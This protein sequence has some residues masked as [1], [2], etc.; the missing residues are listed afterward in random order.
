VAVPKRRTEPIETKHAACAT[1][2]GRR[3]D[4]VACPNCGEPVGPSP[5]LRC[6]RLLQGQRAVKPGTVDEGLANVQARDQALRVAP[7][8][9]GQAGPAKASPADEL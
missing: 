2:Q 6:L 5:R 7:N 1:R 9:R 4:L 3:A 8:S